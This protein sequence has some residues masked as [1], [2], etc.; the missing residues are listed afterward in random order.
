MHVRGRHEAG[1]MLLEELGREGMEHEKSRS[2]MTVVISQAPWCT[3]GL[4]AGSGQWAV[5]GRSARPPATAASRERIRGRRRGRRS[6]QQPR[7]DEETIAGGGVNSERAPLPLHQL[8]CILPVPVFHQATD[9]PGFFLFPSTTPT[10]EPLNQ[11]YL[12]AT[13][14]FGKNYRTSCSLNLVV[15]VVD[16]F[17]DHHDA[18]IG[19]RWTVDLETSPA[20]HPFV[21][22]CGKYIRLTLSW[23]VPNS[24]NTRRMETDRPLTGGLF[25]FDDSPSIHAVLPPSQTGPVTDGVLGV[26][27]V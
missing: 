4:W 24:G 6:E 25:Q 1:G 17:P 22:G 8:P 13:Q 19:E 12:Q 23:K 27:T 9:E 16:L 26:H 3:I 2:A 7:H 10:P 14:S 20:V 21:I 15:L 11:E 18:Q 5:A